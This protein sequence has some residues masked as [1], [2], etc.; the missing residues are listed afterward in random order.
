MNI[1]KHKD[2]TS[3]K[4]PISAV[5]QSHRPVFL[6]LNTFTSDLLLPTKNSETIETPIISHK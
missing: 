4:P 3:H 5:F 6:L 1:L 2:T